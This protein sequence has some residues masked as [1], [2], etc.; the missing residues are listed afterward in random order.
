MD[1]LTHK[2]HDAI[3]AYVAGLMT[4]S[5]RALFEGEM[6]TNEALQQGVALERH[7]RRGM[8]MQAYKR[9][10]ADLIQKARLR[11]T[12]LERAGAEV[13]TSEITPQPE[14]VPAH[15]PER[16][17]SG[18]MIWAAAACL[19]ALLGVGW[20]IWWQQ[21]PVPGH[22]PMAQNDT[23]SITPPLTQPDSI[24]KD[25][26]PALVPPADDLLAENNRR[27]SNAYFNDTP[28]PAPTPGSSEELDADPLTDSTAIARDS[29]SVYRAARLMGGGLDRQAADT[30][31]KVVVQG[32][33]GHWRATAEWYLCLAYLRQNG[34]Q[35]ARAIL[36]RIARTAGHPYQADAKRLRN[37]IR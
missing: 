3:T 5:E 19:A 6:A 2:Q 13:P 16:S 14:L 23:T 9:E 24:T 17:R 18:S 29:A 20:L 37:E 15:Q 10:A 12:T 36:N 1:E 26:P 7:I 31:Q 30:L 11:R 32:Y 21:Q 4:D 8:Q 27:L 25:P 33:P 28:K 34:R 35:Q 22:G